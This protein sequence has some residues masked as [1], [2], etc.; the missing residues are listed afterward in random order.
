MGMAVQHLQLGFGLSMRHRFCLHSSRFD[1]RRKCNV[2]LYIAYS[3]TI[4]A[5]TL[6]FITDVHD[7]TVPGRR[8]A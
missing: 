6:L 2:S 8:F 5:L 3:C 7:D 1:C 4:T